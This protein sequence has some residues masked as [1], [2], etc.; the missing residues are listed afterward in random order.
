MM[1]STCFFLFCLSL[2]FIGNVNGQVKTI[3]VKSFDEVIINPHI[4]TV[5][6]ASDE[7]KVVIEFLDLAEDK[8]NVEVKGN[9]LHLYL[10][11]ARIYT[12]SEKV[13]NGN[14]KYKS[15]IY[16]GTK[17]KV[18]VYY[19]ELDLVSLRG[20]ERHELQSVLKGESFKMNIYGEA[21]VFVNGLDL[22]EFKTNMYGEAYLEIKDGTVD[23]QKMV[24]YGEG[25]IN[26]VAVN[27]QNA[28][29]TAYGEADVR[30]NVSETLKVTAYGEADIRYK[31]SPEINKGI[32][33][34]EARISKMN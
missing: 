18:K 19:K 2:V 26:T 1:K 12:K 10:D 15:Q 25:R 30:L 5:F 6:E 8:M 21:E 34:G 33:L 3:E 9:S 31:G 7:E 4:E 29:V 23:T 11:D 28:R 27:I 32:I 17:A 22:E 24:C 14:Y 20:D 13:K 16:D